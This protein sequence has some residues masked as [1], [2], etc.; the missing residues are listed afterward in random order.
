MPSLMRLLSPAINVS[1]AYFWLSTDWQ[2]QLL[3]TWR[4]VARAFRQQSG[5]AGYDVIN[6][7]HSFPLPPFR[8]DKDQLWPFYADS[9]AAIGAA[10]DAF[11]AHGAG[12]VWWQWRENYGWGVRSADGR[13]LNKELLA[14]LARP[15]VAAAPRGVAAP[16]GD[17]VK[18]ALDIAV[19]SRHAAGIIDVA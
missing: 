11:D 6:E 16:R 5:V 1:T 10:L 15:Y 18:G 2:T 12:W 19:A 9:V 13:T 14:M 8:F 3:A 7:P 17:G 4:W